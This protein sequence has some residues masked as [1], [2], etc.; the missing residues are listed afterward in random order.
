MASVGDRGKYHLPP[1]VVIVDD[2]AGRLATSW[3]Q[4]GGV[5]PPVMSVLTKPSA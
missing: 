1:G 3:D 2:G 4:G 5:L